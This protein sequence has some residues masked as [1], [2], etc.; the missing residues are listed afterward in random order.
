MKSSKMAPREAKAPLT[1][2]GASGTRKLL[3]W[4]RRDHSK[5]SSSLRI[6]STSAERGVGKRKRSRKYLSTPKP[7]ERQRR[8]SGGDAVLELID[9]GARAVHDAEERAKAEKYAR[10]IAEMAIET[11]K[12]AVKRIQELEAELEGSHTKSRFEVH[13]K[14]PDQVVRSGVTTLA[15]RARE[16]VIAMAAYLQPRMNTDAATPS[17]SDQGLP[18]VGLSEIL[19]RADAALSEASAS[20]PSRLLYHKNHLES[21]R[22]A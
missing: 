3:G 6:D 14:T 1:S 19:A 4:L 11:L 18:N 12:H 10:S 2:S 13:K 20:A 17:I 9:Q 7:A 5:A 8:F 16:K 15:V 22:A 21:Q